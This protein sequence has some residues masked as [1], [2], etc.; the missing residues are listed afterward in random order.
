MDAGVAAVGRARTTRAGRARSENP[1]NAGLRVELRVRRGR[2]CPSRDRPCTGSACRACRRRRVVTQTASTVP[3]SSQRT[4]QSV[5][6]PSARTWS[7]AP[8]SGQAPRTSRPLIGDPGHAVVGQPDRAVPPGRRL[9]ARADRRAP[10]RAVA[11]RRCV[12][13]ARS[14]IERP[15]LAV[16]DAADQESPAEPAGEQRGVV[17]GD[18]LGARVADAPDVDVGAGGAVGGPGREREPRAVGRVGGAGADD[19]RRRGRSRSRRPGPGVTS[20]LGAGSVASRSAARSRRSS[21]SRSRRLSWARAWRTRL[22]GRRR[23]AG[24]R[25]AGRRGDPAASLGR[26]SRRRIA[27]A[28]RRDVVAGAGGGRRRSGRRAAVAAA[29]PRSAVGVAASDGR[30]VAGAVGRRVACCLSGRT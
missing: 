30:G 25:L 1:A 21:G 6:G 28:A 18:G 29:V 17:V 4:S 19:A 3:C 15:R 5:I 10:H 7:S 8:P 9:A 16:D 13:S 11:G 2:R 27:G 12:P 24:G 22:V 23:V 20:T 26:S 14:R